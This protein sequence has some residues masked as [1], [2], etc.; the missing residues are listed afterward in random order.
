LKID[1]NKIRK[2]I[3]ELAEKG[4]SKEDSEK[5]EKETL[6]WLRRQMKE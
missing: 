2:K 3:D 5:F 6:A 4:L 1:W